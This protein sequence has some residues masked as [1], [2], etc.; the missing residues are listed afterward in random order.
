MREHD[1]RRGR[2]VYRPLSTTLKSASINKG[3]W[4][5]R[6]T[7]TFSATA[8]TGGFS[9]VAASIDVRANLIADSAVSIQA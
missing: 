1:W 2:R 3:N 6:V 9:V 8:T 7:R 4:R 5:L